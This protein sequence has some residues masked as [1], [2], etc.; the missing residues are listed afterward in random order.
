MGFGILGNYK[1]KDMS[2]I[3]SWIIDE[4]E[5]DEYTIDYSVD[6]IDEQWKSYHLDIRKML[7]AKYIQC[8]EGSKIVVRVKQNYEGSEYLRDDTNKVYYGHSGYD[9][10]YKDIEGQ[11]WDFDMTNELSRYNENSTDGDSGQFSYI[12]YS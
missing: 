11:E 3:V 6:Q 10:Y 9:R 2:Y 1:G 8:N 12:Y 5:S 4:E 7:G